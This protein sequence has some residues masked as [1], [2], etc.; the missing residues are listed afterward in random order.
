MQDYEAAD[1]RLNTRYKQIMAELPPAARSA[2]RTEQ[3]AWVKARDSGCKEKVKDSEE[4]SMWPM[5]Y[6]GC[7]AAVTNQRTRELQEWAVK[8]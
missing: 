8:K 3:R 4:G 7:L 1:R 6:F 2:L 5:E